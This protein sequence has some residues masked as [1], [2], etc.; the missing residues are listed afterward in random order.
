[1]K[2]FSKIALILSLCA[3][4]LV[5]LTACSGT[6]EDEESETVVTEEAFSTGRSNF[7]VYG[8]TTFQIVPTFAYGSSA[9]TGN[10]LITEGELLVGETAVPVYYVYD[11]IGDPENPTQANLRVTLYDAEAYASNTDLLN[12]LGIPSTTTITY[13]QIVY[14]FV[15]QNCDVIT[16]GIQTRSVNNVAE[17]VIVNIAHRDTPFRIVGPSSF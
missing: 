17:D 16:S 5:S 9:E 7:V 3:L 14:D 12:G 8:P 2:I 13:V 11:T 6:G 4:P 10:N 1:M 15:S